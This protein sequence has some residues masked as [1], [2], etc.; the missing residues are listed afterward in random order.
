MDNSTEYLQD[1][2][3][4]RQQQIEKEKF[5]MDHPRELTSRS[6][7][8]YKNKKIE[9]Q[10]NTSRTSCEDAESSKV[11][12]ETCPCPEAIASIPMAQDF[13]SVSLDLDFVADDFV[14]DES[15]NVISPRDDSSRE[16]PNQVFSGIMVQQARTK[17]GLKLFI[18]LQKHSE[19]SQ[20]LHQS[21]TA[22][23]KRYDRMRE[24]SLRE[25]DSQQFNAKL[26]SIKQ[27]LKDQARDEPV[28]RKVMVLGRVHDRGRRSVWYYDTLVVAKIDQERLEWIMFYCEGEEYFI[29]MN[30]E[31]TESQ[32][33]YYLSQGIWG[34][35]KKSAQA[36]RLTQQVGKPFV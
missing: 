8:E 26:E 13:V 31:L 30:Q 25:E 29:E 21:A 15:G 12:G 17:M 2:I 27:D 23:L 24:I 33:K 11:S 5:F 14:K 6:R 20:G 19:R 9:K 28:T 22:E 16:T 36:P 4:R 7:E 1:L 32:Q 35:I 3:S 10:N 18:T 34:S